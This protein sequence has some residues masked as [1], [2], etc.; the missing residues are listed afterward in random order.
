VEK[1]L[2]DTLL[3]CV[4]SFKSFFKEETAETTISETMGKTRTVN[5]LQFIRTS[6]LLSNKMDQI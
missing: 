2:T 4:G 1:H 5:N 6:L 3:P